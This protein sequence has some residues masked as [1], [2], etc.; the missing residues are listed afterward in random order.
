MPR[1][2]PY[3]INVNWRRNCYNYRRFGYITRYYRERENQE[4]IRQ[5]KK[6][7]YEDNRN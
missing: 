6:V 3:V 4:R 7:N 1:C 2:D 5:E